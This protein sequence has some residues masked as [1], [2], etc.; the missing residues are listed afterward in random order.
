MK[1]KE[2]RGVNMSTISLTPEG[3]AQLE[4]Y[5]PQCGQ[6]LATVL[7]EAVS[8]YLDWERQEYEETVEGIRGGYVDV[9]A[10]RTRP[11]AEVFAE[12]RQ[13]YGFPC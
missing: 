1:G 11:A 3:E 2:R 4:A 7:D 8:S 12:V 9:K 13:K 6:D 10:G 5:A